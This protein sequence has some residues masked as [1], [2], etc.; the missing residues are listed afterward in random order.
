VAGKSRKAP[1]PAAIA[2]EALVSLTVNSTVVM[3][4][5]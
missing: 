2:G 4:P 3:T 1:P 5:N